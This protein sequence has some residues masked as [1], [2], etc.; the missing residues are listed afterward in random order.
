[1]AWAPLI[2]SSA[3]I[4]RHD[5]RRKSVYRLE[6]YRFQHS[7]LFKYTAD[8]QIIVL[9]DYCAVFFE[10]IGHH[11]KIRVAGFILERDKYDVVGRHGPL[12]DNRGPG[13]GNYL[14]FF[15]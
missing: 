3:E 6:M 1:M 12:A 2:I 10:Y 4:M 13:D 11:D 9:I 15:Q 5:L 8:Y 7:S 14:S